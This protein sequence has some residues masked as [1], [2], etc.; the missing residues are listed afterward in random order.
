MA[1][2]E[3][4]KSNKFIITFLIIIILILATV[5]T[6]VLFP[7]KFINIDGKK[8]LNTVEIADLNELNDHIPGL[9]TIFVS[10]HYTDKELSELVREPIVHDYPVNDIALSFNDSGTVDIAIS[11]GDFKTFFSGQPLPAFLTGIISSQNIYANISIV[12]ESGNRVR[13]TVNSAFLGDLSIP[14]ALFTSITDELTNKVEENLNQIDGFSLTSI[15][16][17]SDVIKINGVIKK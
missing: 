7:T 3:R 4:K 2:K 15:I 1:K 13:F 11:T 9:G 6:F 10:V 8:I 14:T 16:I 5:L 12:H 17:E